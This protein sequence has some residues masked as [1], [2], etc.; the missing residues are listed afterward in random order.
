MFA[1]F[2]VYSLS[3]KYSEALEY[4]ERFFTLIANYFHQS[5]SGSW[6]FCTGTFLSYVLSHLS[7]GVNEEQKATK[8]RVL[9]R[10]LNGRATKRVAPSEHRLTPDIINKLVHILRPLIHHGLHSKVMNLSMH[11]ATAAKELA[12]LQPGKVVEPLLIEAAEGLCSVSSR[13][14]TFA[15]LKRLASLTLLF[16]DGDI[17]LNGMDYLT[18]ALELT[19]PGI[20]PNDLGKTEYTLKFIAGAAARLQSIFEEDHSSGFED[21][22]EDYVPQILDRTFSKLESLE[23]PP[24][25]NRNGVYS[26]GDSHL[27]FFMFS[28]AIE[29]LFGALPGTIAE[30]ATHRIAQK[31]TGS[32]FKNGMKYYGVLVR[33]AAAATTVSRGGSSVSIF[34]PS[35]IRSILDDGA[36]V[37]TTKKCLA[38]VSGTEMVW[39]IRMLAQACRAVGCGIGDHLDEIALIIRLAMDKSSHLTYKDG[40]RL[41]RGVHEGLTSLQ[42]K[43]GPGTVSEH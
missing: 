4:S 36:A 17:F 41:L 27:S 38:T 7:S 37:E 24:K 21:F 34:V 14:R 39:R 30:S 26:S 25:K 28:V 23:A 3:P 40:G 6:S 19:L 2:A 1:I 29:N 33:A 16:V 31:L 35:L 20:D 13:H 22:L 5:N 9:T 12:L 10:V 8:A 32:A 42:I 43:F 18:Q 11:S 15:A